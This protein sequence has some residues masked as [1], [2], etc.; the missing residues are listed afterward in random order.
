[1]TFSGASIRPI[2]TGW[3]TY[4]ERIVDVVREMP[5]AELQV[6]PARDR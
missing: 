3:G 6:R 4:N 5:N 2:Y 1:M